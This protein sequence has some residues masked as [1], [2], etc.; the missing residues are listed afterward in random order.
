MSD[1]INIRFGLEASASVGAVGHFAASFGAQIQA[2][3]GGQASLVANRP[4]SV[5]GTMAVG[6]VGSAILTLGPS[7][8]G[9]SATGSQEANGRAYLTA[10]A[11][12]SLFGVYR[13]TTPLFVL[14]GLGE[15]VAE[16]SYRAYAVNIANSALT[17]YDNFPFNHLARFE[18]KTIVFADDGAY[19]LGGDSD[20]GD[21]I[22]A[23]AEL[24][25]GDMGTSLLKR[26]P[27]MYIGVMKGG[28]GLRVSAIG[29]EVA[30]VASM[31][32]TN[33][34][35]RRAKVS[36]GMK[37]RFWAARIENKNGEDFAVD[38][39]EYLPMVLRRKV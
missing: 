4:F 5:S 39:V 15:I 18:G 13:G 29:D 33:G 12:R 3:G 26:M 35:N 20:N 37:A 23:V 22:D 2:Y 17:E 25:P 10:P 1:S 21:D 38:S 11:F 36:R 19:L 7:A 24:P 16:L 30:T 32:T 8:F 28:A 6:A 34:R 9:F 31:T 27:F 14:R